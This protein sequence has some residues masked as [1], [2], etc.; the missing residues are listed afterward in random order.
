MNHIKA[1]L[2]IMYF[3]YWPFLTNNIRVLW[4]HFEPQQKRIKGFQNQKT[5][6]HKNMIEMKNVRLAV[7]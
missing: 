7:V 5:E 2:T 1:F 4:S 6:I 3:L